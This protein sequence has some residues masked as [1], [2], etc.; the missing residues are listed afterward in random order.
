MGLF[1]DPHMKE[2]VVAPRGVRLLRMIWQASRLHY[3]VFREI[4]FESTHV[5]CAI[6]KA[7]L[8]A[9]IDIV[10]AVSASRPVEQAA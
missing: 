3:A 6:V 4:R 1:A 2:L 10:D 7:L 5:E 9:A 8:D